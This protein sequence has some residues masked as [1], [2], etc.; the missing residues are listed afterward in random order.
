MNYIGSCST[1]LEFKSKNS[2]PVGLMG[3]QRKVSAPMEVISCDLMGPLPRSS[4][5]FA[6]VIV[7]TCMF[8]K[9]VWARPLREATPVL[10]ACTAD[11]TYNT[12]KASSGP[13]SVCFLAA[14]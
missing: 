5:G 4:G 8:S 6:H 2:A 10:L 11:K 13:V 9:Y 3:A 7:S 14:S 1:C 12:R